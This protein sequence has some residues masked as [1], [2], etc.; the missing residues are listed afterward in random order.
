MYSH[1]CAHIAIL[2]HMWVGK[3]DKPQMT[4]TLWSELKT[5]I[6]LS[7]TSKFLC[8]HLLRS[9][10]FWKLDFHGAFKGCRQ[11]FLTTH[12]TMKSNGFHVTGGFVLIMARLSWV[13]Q[14]CFKVKPMTKI[15]YRWKC[16]LRATAGLINQDK[17]DDKD[18]WELH[19]AF[20]LWLLSQVS[21]GRM[22]AFYLSL[23]VQMSWAHCHHPFSYHP[24]QW[25]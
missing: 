6:L 12:T 19:A 10:L 15:L 7:Q 25:C 11:L 9:S 23:V 2:K 8:W 1:T 4:I 5:L 21:Q 14:S 13:L 24:D 18:K 3:Q 17:R 20:L 16:L 22:V